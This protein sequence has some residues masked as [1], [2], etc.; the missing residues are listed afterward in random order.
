MT[1]VMKYYEK[2]YDLEIVEK[3]GKIESIIYPHKDEKLKMVLEGKYWR[4]S[5]G[6]F[7]VALPNI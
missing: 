2:R 5:L 7:T 6:K 1:I 4:A 3:D